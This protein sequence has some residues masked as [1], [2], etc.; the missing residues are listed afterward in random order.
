MKK[1]LLA[2][3]LLA[4]PAARAAA[5]PYFR[6]ILQDPTHPKISASALYTSRGEFDGGVTDVALVYHKASAEDTL[7][8][9]QLLELGAPPISWTLVEVGAGGN[10]QTAYVRGGLAVDVAP[11]LLG[12]L[13]QALERAGGLAAKF[14]NLIASHDGSGVKLSLGW[15]T[16]VVRNGGVPPLNEWSFPPRYGIGYCV[17]F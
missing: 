13:T 4:G 3:L 2:A 12:P 14:G 17:A 6:T 9:R 1:T 11:T 5:D 7:W 10:R 16:T 15:K 8:P